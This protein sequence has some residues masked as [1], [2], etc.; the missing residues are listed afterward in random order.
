MKEVW[1]SGGGTQSCAI[2]ALIIQ[3]KLPKPDIAVMANTGRETSATFEYLHKWVQPALDSVG[4]TVYVVNASDYSY[5]GD[6]IVNAQ[7]T[8]LI[9]A[10][11]DLGGQK[12]K[13]PAYC[14]AYWKR[15]SID[16]WLSK[17]HGITRSMCKKWLGYGKEEQA[18]WV[19]CMAS[20]EYK[21]GLLRLPLV[22]DY[23]M[24]RHECQMLI[25]K[26][27]WPE[28]PRSRCWM[29]PN[30]SDSE[31]RSLTADEFEKAIKFDEELRKIDKH[32][33]LHSS[34]KPLAEVDLAM[35]DDLFSRA[36]DSGLCFV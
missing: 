31:W 25:K 29:C 8:L 17:E 15:D 20:D 10:F 1:S 19:R 3:G 5:C 4:V 21:S 18:R 30:Q 35:P 32:A 13:L 24:R 26:M 34:C 2:A 7:G 9:P 16:R 11:S 22:V 28:A 36:C 33:F 6:S 14:S 27:G 23:P 12:S